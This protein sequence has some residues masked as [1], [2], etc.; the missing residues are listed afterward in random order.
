MSDG[1]RAITPPRGLLETLGL[2]RRELR[3]WATYDWALS[4]AQTVIM[5]AV[6]PIY[7]VTV[8]AK[9]L[10]GESAA[11][12][13]LAVANTIAL[14]IVAVISPFIGAITD[15]TATK[16]KALALVTVAGAGTAMAMWSIGPNEDHLAS[17]LFIGVM[18]CASACLVFYEG[19]LPH[20]AGPREI[21]RVSTAGYAIGYF[22]GGIL[23]VFNLLW[24]TK[25]A[26][27]GLPAGSNLT[28]DE[29][30]LPARLALVSVGVW[31]LVFS[32]P[33]FLWVPEQSA[34]PRAERLSA[35]AIVAGAASSVV[36]TVRELR[37][38]KQ[39]FLMLIAF[40]IYN[41][42]IQTIIKMA[43][44][45]GKEIGIGTNDLITAV[46]IV[47]FAGVPFT[48]LFARLAERMGA[49]GAV[50]VGLAAYAGISVLGYFMTS[51]LHFYILALAVGLVQG[52][53]PFRSRVSFSGSTA[54]SKNSLA[55]LARCSSP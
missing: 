1:P 3:A 15:V 4:A 18:V 54:C 44:A 55:C 19:L 32:I 53:V 16:R 11:T 36:R 49:K 28:P 25:P 2:H 42:G 47:Q 23:L 45:Y 9:H 5:T 24:I 8:A 17:A 52:G 13:Q 22:G 7:Y 6:F 35:G 50:M 33:L 37:A 41:D 26:W 21:D 10:V 14:L 34:P 38:F 27:F 39:A 30:T 48:F 51:A 46:L 31:W 20:I 29:A 43:T 12:Q 40:M